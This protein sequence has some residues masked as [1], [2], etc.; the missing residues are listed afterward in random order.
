MSFQRVRPRDGMPL[1]NTWRWQETTKTSFYFRQKDSSMRTLIAL[2]FVAAV[3]F[4]ANAAA[5][6]V[7]G[8]GGPSGGPSGGASK[9]SGGTGAASGGAAKL[10]GGA[11]GGK[12]G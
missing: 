1:A 5:G 3:A 11:G 9:P 6:T 4:S 10:G 12:S 8:G 2:S 7:G